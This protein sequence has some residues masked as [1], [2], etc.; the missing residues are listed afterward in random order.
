MYSVGEKI[1]YGENGVCIV[2]K[3]APLSMSGSGDK[4]YYYLRPIVGT[5]DYYAPVD[6]GV[7]MRPVIGK[8]E[9]DELIRSIPEI[10]PAV[11]ND[12]RFN[13]VDAF[14]KEIFMQ[15]TPEAMV[16]IIKGLQ[17]RMAEKKT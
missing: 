11:C 12:S 5:G 10:E 6:T 9:A 2:E 16:S 13:H 7:F 8:K 4:M 17:L 14:Y 1:I 15:H 3:I